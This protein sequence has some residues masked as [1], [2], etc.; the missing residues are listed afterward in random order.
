MGYPTEL[1]A[2]GLK[3][4]TDKS[5]IEHDYLTFYEERLSYLKNENFLMIE[6][7]V[8]RGGSLR[9][10]GEY[11]PNATIVGIDTTAE[12]A[13]HAG[14]NRHVVIGNAVDPAVIKEVIE[15]F[16]NPT[17]VLDDGSHLWNDQIQA[18]RGF[19]PSILPGGA[20]I[21]ED[22]HTSMS[23]VIDVD[24]AYIQG[25]DTSAYDYIQKI[26][27]RV[28]GGGFVTDA[29]SDDDFIKSESD[30]IRTIEWYF[31]TCIIRKK[32]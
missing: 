4:G 13:E 8:L 32:I 10:W 15:K 30:K 1:N 25:C 22:L 11:F 7:G 18:L 23:G 3:H 20:F 24:P 21:M 17:I 2:I 12:T 6:I 14:D 19:W 5:S 27:K 9:T 29:A 16:G 26:N 28:L 31:K